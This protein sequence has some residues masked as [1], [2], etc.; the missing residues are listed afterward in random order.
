MVQEPEPIP[1]TLIG[2]LLVS[3]AAIVASVL[4]LWLV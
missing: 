1:V 3:A 2:V 4:I